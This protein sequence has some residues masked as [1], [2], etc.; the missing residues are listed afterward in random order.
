LIFIVVV[1]GRIERRGLSGGFEVFGQLVR[2]EDRFDLG[3]K[4][5]YFRSKLGVVLRRFEEVEEF[6]ADE[7]SECIR[8]A[9][10]VFDPTGCFALFDPDFAGVHRG[11]CTE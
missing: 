1:K 3:G 4:R 5:R 6:L 9:E 10:F 2:L 11:H 8:H 7:V